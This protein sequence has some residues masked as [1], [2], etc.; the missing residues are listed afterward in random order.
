MRDIRIMLI[1]LLGVFGAAAQ[2]SDL[3][4]PETAWDKAEGE[5][6]LKFGVTLKGDAVEAAWMEKGSSM[7]PEFEEAA[8][9]RRGQEFTLFLFF[10]NCPPNAAK[11]CGAT[12]DYALLD[13][14]GK[15]LVERK[16]LRLWTKPL[17]P[18]DEVRLGAAVLRISAEET[19]PLGKL[20]LRAAVTD[21]AAKMTLALERPIELLP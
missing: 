7:L 5:F 20:T 19:D 11:R 18:K 2:A 17:P 21:P 3:V 16:G 9:V 6:R 13:S 4:K 10:A 14:E 15:L 8:Q 1:L 12:V